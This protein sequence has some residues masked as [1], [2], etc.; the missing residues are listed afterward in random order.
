MQYIRPLPFLPWQH[1]SIY[2]SLQILDFAENFVEDNTSYIR[3]W[4]FVF[5]DWMDAILSSNV[6]SYQLGYFCSVFLSFS[7][8]RARMWRSVSGPSD[9]PCPQ[10]VINYRHVSS[11]QTPPSLPPLCD[12]DHIIILTSNKNASAISVLEEF[13]LLP[14]VSRLYQASLWWRLTLNAQTHKENPHLMMN[15]LAFFV[16]CEEEERMRACEDLLGAD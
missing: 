9:S 8:L 3:S 11:A 1:S 5:G 7:F 4:L 12:T 15:V 6:S 2:C 14:S 16:P 13:L 10:A